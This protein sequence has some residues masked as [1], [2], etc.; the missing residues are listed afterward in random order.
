M[1][2]AEGG[3]RQRVRMKHYRFRHVDHL[4][5]LVPPTVAQFAIFRRGAKKLLVEAS[6]LVKE[7][8]G[9]CKVVGCEEA[10]ALGLSIV[11]GVNGVDDRL[12]RGGVRIV[13][14]PVDRAPAQYMP[15]RLPETRGERS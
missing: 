3:Q 9:H 10:S 5:S 12:A 8:R 11:E 1:L 13:R 7:V 15:G 6:D 4:A 2:T 14:E